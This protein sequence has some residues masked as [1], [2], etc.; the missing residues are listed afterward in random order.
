M[1]N[2]Y[3]KYLMTKDLYGDAYQEIFGHAR[4]VGVVLYF[5]GHT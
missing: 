3:D 5:V 2:T 4:V 1:K